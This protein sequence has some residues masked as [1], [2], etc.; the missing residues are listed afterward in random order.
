[1]ASASGI[2]RLRVT[3]LELEN[4]RNFRSVDVRLQSRV[5]L[6]GP[7]ASGKSNL[8]DVFRFLRDIVGVGGGF[9]HAVAQRGGV[10][11][12]RC[13]AARKS[14]DVAVRVELGTDEEPRQWRYELVFNQDSQQRPLLKVERVLRDDDVLLE[15]PNPDDESDSER[16]T[17][18]Y[19]EQ[20]H[21]N[22]Q[23]RQLAVFFGAV[24]YLHIIPQLVRE[25][26]RV[27][28][29][30]EDPYGADFLEQLAK[31]N[32]RT[33]ESRLRKILEALQAAVPQFG[34]LELERDNRGVPHVR[35]KYDHWRPRGAWQTERDLSDGTLRLMGF[36]WALL[37]G[38]G[39]L[40]LEEPELSLHPSIVRELPRLLARMQAQTQRQVVI[41]THSTDL[42]ADEGIGLDE[43]LLLQPR[44]E[45]T[46]VESP[47]EIDQ[48][49]LLLESGVPLGDAVLPRTE[50]S[51]LS[52]LSLWET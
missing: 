6:V 24:R 45:G 51:G 22:Q 31:Q 8:I 19:L 21:A 11:R 43:V 32:K 10:S 50:P 1:M 38:K 48:V 2:P 33:R 14:P 9:Q 12:L 49:T 52:Q 27:V 41:S 30:D 29:R 18:T 17:Q 3:K 44:E 25:P 35:A 47:A 4:W 37:D 23:F 42:L 40:L 26:E 36:L 16:L 46:E 34:Q 5:F 15:R 20:V 28:A 7:N 13:L 39:P